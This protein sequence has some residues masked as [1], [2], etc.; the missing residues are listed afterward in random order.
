M[1]CGKGN[2]KHGSNSA[3]SPAICFFYD[4]TSSYDEVL[5]RSRQPSI[6]IYLI[7]SLAV[8]VYKYLHNIA[9]EYLCTL[10]QK[11][12]VTYELRDKNLL[13]QRKFKTVSYGKRSFVYLGSKLWNS[14]NRHKGCNL[15]K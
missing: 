5:K 13:L 8:E 2:I 11:H 1:L 6:L 10:L 14:T 9:P 15:T 12:N 4:F 3:E 7:M